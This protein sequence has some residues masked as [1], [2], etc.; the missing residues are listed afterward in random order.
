MVMVEQVALEELLAALTPLPLVLLSVVGRPTSLLVMLTL[1][2]DSVSSSLTM[3][4]P[5]VL[6]LNM[7]EAWCW[8]GLLVRARLED[9]HVQL[10]L[11]YPPDQG[12]HRHL[13]RA[14]HLYHPVDQRDVCH[15]AASITLDLIDA[16]TNNALIAQNSLHL[17][18][19]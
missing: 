8:L 7:G 13:H 10:E 11:L 15:R 1:V 19:H 14:H 16:R 3:D 17:L 4:V 18:R 9:F 6:D 2:N 5:K 12:L